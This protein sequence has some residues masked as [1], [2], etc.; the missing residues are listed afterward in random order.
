M[1][2]WMPQV[3]QNPS[4]A[5]VREGSMNQPAGMRFGQRPGPQADRPALTNTRQNDVYEKGNIDQRVAAGRVPD[6]DR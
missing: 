2:A 6:R 4:S 3:N 5:T 1:N